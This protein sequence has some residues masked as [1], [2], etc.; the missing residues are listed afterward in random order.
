MNSVT[1]NK[2]RRGVSENYNVAKRKLDYKNMYYNVVFIMCNEVH[3][4]AQLKC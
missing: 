2:K 3:K 4:Q 1:N